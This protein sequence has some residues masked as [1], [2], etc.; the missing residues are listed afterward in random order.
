MKVREGY[1][2]TKIGIIPEGWE[3]KKIEECFEVI[4][5][6]SPSSTSYNEE[7]KGLLL[8]QGNA[9][10]KNN[11]INPRVYTSE[12]TKESYPKD[13]LMTV[14]APV[15]D[16]YISDIHSCIGRGI[17]AIRNANKYLYYYLSNYKNKWNRLAQGSTF[18]AITA[19][20]VEKLNIPIPPPKEQ[21]KIVEILS[22]YDDIIEQQ[23]LLIEK[24][25]EFKKG[26]IQ[27]VF[28]QEIR[29]KDDNEKDYPQWK[30]KRLKDIGSAYNG[31]TGKTSKDFGKGK[32]FITYKNIYDNTKID[33]KI[34]E[35][36]EV[37]STEKQNKV[38]YGDIFFTTS[39]ETPNEV[40]YSS[41]L[42]DEIQEEIYLNSFCFGFRLEDKK[43]N[44]P[45]FFRYLL[46][47]MKFRKKIFILAQGSTRFNLSKLELLNIKIKLPTES[48][49]QKIANFLSNIDNKIELLEKK[50]DLLKSEK[51]GIMQ[52]LITGEIRV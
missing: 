35:L 25:K 29:F 2:K 44:F 24:E 36:V 48:E 46:R 18:T 11:K 23:E 37:R 4:M 3:V 45:E 39:S 27:K 49:Q 20:E 30:E 10:M 34:L 12:I 41:V 15:G 13:I 50:L 6:Q 5:G 22:Y 40:G 16:V 26:M 28:S 52:R 14:R 17:C 19:K 38:E 33:M 32:K 51:K 7:G 47:N 9:D 21:E 42:L 43:K 8:V 31:L 1:K